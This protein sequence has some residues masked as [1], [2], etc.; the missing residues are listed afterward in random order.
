MYFRI[1]IL[2]FC[3]GS[4]YSPASQKTDTTLI[5]RNR[6]EWITIQ[7]RGQCNFPKNFFSDK[8]WNEYKIGFGIPGI[9][10]SFEN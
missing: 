5:Y 9:I 6:E 8:T 3:P 2:G 4:I 7:N 10:K 1:L